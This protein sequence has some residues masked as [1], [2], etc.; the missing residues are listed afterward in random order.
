MCCLESWVPEIYYNIGCIYKDMGKR[1]EEV[2]E[3]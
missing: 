3:Y 2:V 1:E